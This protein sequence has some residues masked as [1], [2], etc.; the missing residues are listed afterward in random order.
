MAF[1]VISTSISIT[2]SLRLKTG[3]VVLVVQY[4]N[5]NIVKQKSSGKRH[6]IAM[7]P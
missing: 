6:G 5:C 1:Y 3:R 7:V 4:F 2:S